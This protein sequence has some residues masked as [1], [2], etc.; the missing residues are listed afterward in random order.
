MS[1]WTAILK[2]MPGR[3]PECGTRLIHRNGLTTTMLWPGTAEA[4]VCPSLCWGKCKTFLGHGWQ[5]EVTDNREFL[6]DIA[7]RLS[8]PVTVTEIK[9][10]DANPA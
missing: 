2:L 4:W 6:M 8:L 10:K 3:C 1:L 7:N 9:D 5:V